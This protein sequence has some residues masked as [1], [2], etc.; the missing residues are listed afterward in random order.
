[1]RINSAKSFFN[2]KNNFAGL[3]VCIAALLAAGQTKATELYWDT[4]GSTTNTWTSSAWG[5][6][7]DGPFTT[8]W[9]SGANATFNAVS[10]LTNATT[11]VGNVTVN[12]N[13][14]VIAAGTLGTSGTISTFTVADDVT[15]TW[16]GQNF[17]TVAGTGFIK[18]GNGIWNMGVQ[19]NKYSGG[20]TLNAGTIL[21]GSATYAFGTNTLTINGGTISSIGSPTYAA[22]S[23]LIGGDF[24]LAGTG[25]ATFG[26]PV[27][28]GA[29]TR[30]ITNNITSGNRIFSGVISGD[31][32]AGLNFWGSGTETL[33][34]VNTYTGNTSINAGTLALSG[35]GSIANTPDITIAGGATL[36]VSA[37]SAPFTLGNGQTF[38]ASG[39]TSAGTITTAPG[40]GLIIGTT[41]SLQFSAFNGATAPLTISGAGTITLASSNVVTVTNVS[42]SAFTAGDYKLI[43]TNGG[44]GSVSGTAPSSVT[45]NGSGIAGGTTASL[46]IS[47]AQLYLEVSAGANTPA[48]NSISFSGSTA[49][50]GVLGMPDSSYVLLTTTNLSG[51]WSPIKTNTTDGSGVLNF[52]DSNA[53]NPQ[54]FYR[55]VQQ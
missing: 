9:T 6:S 48:T 49:N 3:M 32:G 5:T 40:A 44:G 37:L 28:L 8:G 43:S 33:S 51:V 31:A 55:T 21:I 54:Q 29:A 12:A 1:M 11:Q 2:L 38:I 42:G 35:M 23:M 19:G 7:L 52:T 45:V 4:S 15:L 47:N 18:N 30:N 10:T 27:N 36:D 25:N 20:F 41:N 24:T 16:S 53:T 46:V 22:S 26:M 17:S 39:T 14:T 13:T 50:I 34:G